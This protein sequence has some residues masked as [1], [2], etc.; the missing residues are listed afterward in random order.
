MEGL[1]FHEGFGILR[2]LSLEGTVLGILYVHTFFWVGFGV[3]CYGDVRKR[4][5]A[6]LL[7]GEYRFRASCEGL[8]LLM[9]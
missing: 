3:F 6:Y 5:A 4:C 1:L 9:I 7:S 8:L 2:L